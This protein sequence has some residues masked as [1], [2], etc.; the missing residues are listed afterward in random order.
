MSRLEVAGNTQFTQFCPPTGLAQYR[1]LPTVDKA[2]GPADARAADRHQTQ[3]HERRRATC[4]S[5]P[6]LECIC[7]L[8]WPGNPSEVPEVRHLYEAWQKMCAEISN[9]DR[10]I[11]PV[12]CILHSERTWVV[13][14]ARG[15]I[16]QRCR[17]P[18]QSALRELPPPPPA[19]G[20]PLVARQGH[21]A[22]GG[23]ASSRC[24]SCAKPGHR[25]SSPGQQRFLAYT[26]AHIGRNGTPLVTT[27]PR[28][29]CVISQRTGRGCRL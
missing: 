1:S 11:R 15:S 21:R 29:R 14:Q 3:R 10:S 12:A 26:A 2:R 18:T 24:V 20:P 16:L 13:L 4:M 17:K 28:A 8:P 5:M 6:A 7:T 27:F 9:P 23:L 22:Q 25:C 19:T